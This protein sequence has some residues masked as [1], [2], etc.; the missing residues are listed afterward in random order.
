MMLRPGAEGLRPDRRCEYGKETR[1]GGWE[2][3]LRPGLMGAGVGKTE[4]SIIRRVVC[5]DGCLPGRRG[6]R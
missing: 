3:H 6:Q 4:D 5:S 1:V 2:T